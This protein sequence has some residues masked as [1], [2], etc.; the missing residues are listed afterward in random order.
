MLRPSTVNLRTSTRSMTLS[1]A[2]YYRIFK[3]LVN[4]RWLPVYYRCLA[5][6][7]PLPCP[8]HRQVSAND[9]ALLELN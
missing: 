9:I 4:N 7:R 5:L 1:I 2:N 8:T 6:R 3:G